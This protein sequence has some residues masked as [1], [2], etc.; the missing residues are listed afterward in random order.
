MK[1]SEL[2]QHVAEQA[3]LPKKRVRTIL[4]LAFDAISQ[5]IEKGESVVIRGLGKFTPKE[6]PARTRTHPET[7][8]TTEVPARTVVNFRVIKPSKDKEEADS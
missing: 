5:E 1:K 6:Q 4:D 8:E 7:G 3:K 2:V